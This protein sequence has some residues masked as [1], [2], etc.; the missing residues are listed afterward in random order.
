MTQ[1]VGWLYLD[2]QQKV[3]NEK[4]ENK[5]ESVR[6]NHRC[7]STCI[8]KRIQRSRAVAIHRQSVLRARVEAVHGE[9][10]QL[11]GDTKRRTGGRA[12]VAID[13]TTR[14][15]ANGCTRDQTAWSRA[16]TVSRGRGCVRA[17]ASGAPVRDHAAV[18]HV[19]PRR[20][21]GEP[22]AAVAEHDVRLDV[23]TAC[24]NLLLHSPAA[25]RTSAHA[26]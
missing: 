23:H 8:D 1:L 2:G 16:G 12:P 18:A 10:K 17:G 6:P 14:A 20:A 4:T 21:V 25:P 24:A 26:G 19:L 15:D 3:T 13:R 7:Q 22:R 5:S 11:S 9:L